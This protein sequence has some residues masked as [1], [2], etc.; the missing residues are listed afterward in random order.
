MAEGGVGT[1]WLLIWQGLV[2]KG[3]RVSRALG[4]VLADS[5]GIDSRWCQDRGCMGRLAV[6][7]AG[8]TE[9]IQTISRVE[10][11]EG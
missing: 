10:G 1:E 2:W 8:G 5:I 4:K 11:L 3:Q 9:S 6:C 7:E